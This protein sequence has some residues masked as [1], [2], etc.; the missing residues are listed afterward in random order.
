MSNIKTYSELITFP[1][2]KERFVYLKLNGFI[3][4]D[5]FGFERYLNQKMYRSPR[6]R[7]TRDFVIVRDN[8]FDLGIKGL[9]IGGPIYVHHMNPMKPD[10]II[11]NRDHIFN[12]EFLISCSYDTHLAI[13]YSDDSIVDLKTLQYAERRPGDTTLWKKGVL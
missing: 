9:D 10:D 8:G 12:P 13:H 2:F 7:R 4:E 5:T 11:H 3:G 6:W 1:T